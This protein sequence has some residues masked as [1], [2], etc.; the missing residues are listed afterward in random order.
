M[1][2]SYDRTEKS[3]AANAQEKV[4][5]ALERSVAE[6]KT[7]DQARDTLN[8]L[9]KTAGDL[10]EDDIACARDEAGEIPAT[11]QAAEVIAS[12]AAQS[13]QAEPGVKSIVDE[14]VTQALGGV[15]ES[16]QASLD[17]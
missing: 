11:A 2:D 14:S 13:A 6:I 15:A 9:E 16:D 3:D 8:S 17:T 4:R 5:A 7:P 10:R 12:A 1:P